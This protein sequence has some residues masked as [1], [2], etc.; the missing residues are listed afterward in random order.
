MRK[1]TALFFTCGLLILLLSACTGECEHNYG[2]WTKLTDPT[3]SVDGLEVRV[4]EHC[5]AEETKKIEKLAH[6]TEFTSERANSCTEAGT[7][8]GKCT[9]CGETVVETVEVREYD[10]KEIYERALKYVCEIITYDRDGN[11]FALGTGVVCTS[12]GKILTNYHVIEG[13]FSARVKLGDASYSVTSVNKYSEEKDLAVIEIDKR[14]ESYA[15]L[16]TLPLDVGDTVYAMGSPRGMTNTITKGAVTYSVRELEGVKYIQHDASITNGNSGGPL[17]N[18]YG[19]VVGI[20]TMTVRDSQNL[21]FAVCVGELDK[22]TKV[23]NQSLSYLYKYNA[24]NGFVEII[25]TRGV[26]VGQTYGIAEEYKDM[27]WCLMYDPK[28]DIIQIYCSIERSNVKCVT[29]LKLKRGSLSVDYYAKNEY[30]SYSDVA[31][32]SGRIDARKYKKGTELS[33]DAY[34]GDQQFKKDELDL[35]SMIIYTG[36]CWTDDYLESVAASLRLSDLGFTA[37]Y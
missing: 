13:A 8:T 20:N 5:S 6:T 1:T 11:E 4:C 25:K 12:D 18:S 19:E 29:V 10:I 36:L 33:C 24:Y 9:V 23:V 27:D 3:C 34:V 2:E 30:L 28:E 31:E 21:N 37:L 35:M 14:T 26:Y 22:I 17:F 32:A 15:R 16:C 7:K